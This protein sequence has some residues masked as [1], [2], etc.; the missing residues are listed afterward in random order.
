MGPIIEW[1]QLDNRLDGFDDSG[2]MAWKY[3]F[4]IGMGHPENLSPYSTGLPL[5]VMANC[6]YKIPGAP[7]S[8]L[9]CLLS[10]GPLDIFH[11]NSAIPGGPVFQGKSGGSLDTNQSKPI[12]ICRNIFTGIY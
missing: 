6:I 12:S 4:R 5:L 3:S 9:R 1:Q 8:P 11:R 2:V 7:V 10:A